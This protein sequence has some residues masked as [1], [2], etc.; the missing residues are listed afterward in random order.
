MQT[1]QLTATASDAGG[2]V[3]GVAAPSRDHRGRGR[4]GVSPTGL[5]TG[6]KEGQVEIRATTEGVT[7]SIMITVAVA[8]GTPL[9]AAVSPPPGP[10]PVGLQ[11]VA[12]GL[13]FP[14][15]PGIR[16]RATTG[17]SSCRR[18]APSAC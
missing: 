2:T 13:K 5:V 12:T 14:L 1:V 6:L 8:G 11:T 7:G 3:V 16:P 18:P 9:P 17:C 10:V 15:L 4:P